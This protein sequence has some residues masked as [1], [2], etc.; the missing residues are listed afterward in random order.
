MLLCLYR[1][2]LAVDSRKL[3]QEGYDNLCRAKRLEANRTKR[4][5]EY[6]SSKT[7]K[8]SMLALRH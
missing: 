3:L 6:D 7:E 4:L 2:G 5:S 1:L 8:M